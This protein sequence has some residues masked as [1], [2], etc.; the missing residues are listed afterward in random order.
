MEISCKA[1]KSDP[2]NC[3][4][5]GF[6]CWENE[7]CIR[8]WCKLKHRETCDR[9]CPEGKSCCYK[10]GEKKCRDLSSNRNFCGSCEIKC[11]ED[12]ECING[13]CEPWYKSRD[14][15]TDEGQMNC[16]T[17]GEIHCVNIM[18]DDA[19]CGFCD[20]ACPYYAWC[21]NGVCTA[22]GEVIHVQD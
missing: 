1:I 10:R 12:E 16:G 13:S 5:C 15:C 11:A 7:N 22:E 6:Q 8:G 20:R 21:E 3:G 19:N 14:A 17:G 2:E 4:W 18:T 9:N